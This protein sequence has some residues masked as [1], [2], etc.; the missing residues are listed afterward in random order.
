M[1]SHA[2]EKVQGSSKKEKEPDPSTDNVDPM[3]SSLVNNGSSCPSKP[4]QRKSHGLGF[5][6]MPGNLLEMEGVQTT[7]NWAKRQG[8]RVFLNRPLN[9]MLSDRHP[10]R[11]ASYSRPQSP[12]YAEAKDQ[13]LETLSATEQWDGRLQP[14]MSR[15]REMIESLDASLRVGA[16]STMHLEGPSIMNLLRQEL[17]VPDSVKSSPQQHPYTSLTSAQQQAISHEN[18]F[19][20]GPHNGPLHRRSRYSHYS[21][22]ISQIHNDMKGSSTAQCTLLKTSV[23]EVDKLVKCLDQYVQI[24]HQQ[25]RFQESSRVEKMLT[26][27]GIDLRGETVE[28][29]ALEHL[30]EHEQIDSMLL[31]MKR[32]AYVDFAHDMLKMMAESE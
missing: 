5:F 12:S 32:D 29:F 27:R 2:F 18:S 28:K 8:L 7:A 4:Y 17:T 26:D 10:V 21:H 9:A 23:F 22:A 14:G 13:I 15:L 1:A 24:F 30:L 19:G 6:Q 11:L 31:G 25:V 3:A 16:I 20:D